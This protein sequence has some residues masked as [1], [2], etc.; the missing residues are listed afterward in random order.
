MLG[1]KQ[2]RCAVCRDEFLPRNSLQ[3]VCGVP[4]AL[5]V[6]AANWQKEF[7]KETRKRKKAISDSDPKLW[8]KKAQAMFNAYI[9]LRDADCGCISCNKPAN[10]QG[11]WAAGHYRTVGAHPELRF[12]ELNVHKQCNRD[13]NSG[14]SG[15][16]L[17]YRIR[18]IQKIGL[19]NVDF[20]EGAHEPARYR[21]E[22]YKD[23]YRVYREKLKHMKEMQSAIGLH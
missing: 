2:K 5:K 3:K 17:E 22:D 4:C 15:N 18:L 19:L 13:C 12:N 10:W 21:I 14:K 11:Q 7:D 8:A 20:L 16:V 9:R 6:Y 1:R 23:I